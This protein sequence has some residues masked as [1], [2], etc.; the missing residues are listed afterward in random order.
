M[1][2]R[3]AAWAFPRRVGSVQSYIAQVTCQQALARGDYEAAYWHASRV[4]PAGR[5]APHSPLTLWLLLDLTESAVRSGRGADASA[6]VAAV[7]EAGIARLSP[8]LE[9]M[10]LGATALAAPADEATHWFDAAL[11]APDGQRYP[12]ELA[13]IQLAYGE[14]LRRTQHA[15]T[16]RAQ[17]TEAKETFGR[18]R[19][20]PW[21]DRAARE[22]R[23]TGVAKPGRHPG[24]GLPDLTLTPQQRQVAELAASGLTNKQIAERLFLSPRTVS[25]HLYELFPKLGI[26][27]RAALRDALATY[28]PNRNTQD[29]ADPL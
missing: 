6:H 25:T 12:F 20:Q 3:M 2:D 9:L 24:Q 1:I 19:A 16:A 4:S 13:R 28:T 14:H 29:E 17:L 22:L 5:L 8:R 15:A 11:A 21:A 10:T 23:A 26:T 18:L 7:T 27:S